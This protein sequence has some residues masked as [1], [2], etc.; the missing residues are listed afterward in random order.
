MC[1]P[2]GNDCV[3]SRVSE[4]QRKLVVGK[5]HSRRR[6]TRLFSPKRSQAPEYVRIP[7]LNSV[8]VNK[9]K[10]AVCEL[11]R[12]I[13]FCVRKR[14]FKHAVKA[15]VIG[16]NDAGHVGVQDGSERLLHALGTNGYRNLQ[17]RDF[18]WPN[19]KRSLCTALLHP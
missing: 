8:G 5:L 12:T 6:S 17:S 14:S 15:L 18:A 2:Y 19:I 3:G 10:S 13:E 4:E 1:V 7:N 16:Q 9:R 11:Q